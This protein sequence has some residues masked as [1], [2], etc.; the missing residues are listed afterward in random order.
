M[1]K[2]RC[3]LIV[4]VLCCVVPVVLAQERRRSSGAPYDLGNEQTVTAKVDRVRTIEPE[5]GVKMLIVTV[6]RDDR[7]LHLV[8]GP[9]DW[10]AAQQF[11][12]A[13]GEDVEATGLAGGRFDGGPAMR[14]RK[15]R[16]GTRTLDLLDTAGEPN[17]K[18]SPDQF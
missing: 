10:I 8:T 2:R 13:V 12:F 11:A 18:Q 5:P 4:T 17:W 15:V 7:L 14:V 1:S 6:K 9:P 3:L 16:I